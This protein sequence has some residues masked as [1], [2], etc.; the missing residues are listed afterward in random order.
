MARQ[1]TGR[2]KR[3][4]PQTSYEGC[5]VLGYH[6]EHCNILCWCIVCRTRCKVCGNTNVHR[7]V[8]SIVL[9]IRQ[10]MVDVMG[11]RSDVVIAVAMANKENMDELLS[12]YALNMYVQKHNLLPEWEVGEYQGAWVAMHTDEHVKWYDNYEDVTGFGA[13]TKLAE[14]FWEERGLPYAYRFIRVG[15]EYEDIEVSCNESD[16]GGHDD[17]TGSHLADLLADALQVQT[18]ITNEV[19][20]ANDN[21]VRN[22][23][24]T[25]EGTD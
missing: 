19:N 10:N 18:T 4:I 8:Y 2:E 23:V 24:H 6:D 14:T 22:S 1:K 25:N 15:E 12:V 17:K 16:C 11:Y 9:L 21:T 20:F 3:G 7:Y 5:N 13:L